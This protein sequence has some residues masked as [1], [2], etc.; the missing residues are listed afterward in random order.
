MKRMKRLP[1]LPVLALLCVPQSALATWSVVALN[2]RTGQIVV[3]SATCVTGANLER[4]APPFG[5]RGLQAIVVPGRAAAAAQANVDATFAN[6]KLIYEE[7]RKGTNPADVV[8]LLSSDPAFASRQFGII[9]MT[10]RA[11][12]HSGSGNE[13]AALHLQGQVPGEPIYYSIQGNVLANDEVVIDAVKA[14]VAL[15]GDLTDRVMAAMEAADVKGGD[16]RCSCD[17]TP[18]TKAPCLTKTSHVAYILLA[19]KTD[20]NKTSFGDGDYSMFISVTE[21]DIK[22]EEDGNPVKTLRLRYDAWK[23]AG[24]PVRR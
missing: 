2:S 24:P 20:T 22:P 11:A 17:T 6:Q 8:R 12:G 23:K 7:L 18:K 5:L 15:K 14:F 13:A 4:R 10:G 9:D 19:E 3:A 21:S 1:L 16:R